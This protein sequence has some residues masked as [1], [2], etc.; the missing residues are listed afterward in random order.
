[1]KNE[2]KTRICVLNVSIFGEEVVVGSTQERKWI[3][4]EEKPNEK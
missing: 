4:R 1:V 3:R 2:G